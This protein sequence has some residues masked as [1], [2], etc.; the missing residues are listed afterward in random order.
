MLKSYPGVLNLNLLRLSH[1]NEMKLKLNIKNI[2]RGNARNI[3]RTTTVHKQLANS[4]NFCV[5]EKLEI[6]RYQ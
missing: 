5:I 1:M 6:Y 4:G 3:R 2:A